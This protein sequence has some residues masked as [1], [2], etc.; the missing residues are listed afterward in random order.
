MRLRPW[1]VSMNFWE[2]VRWETTDER[3]GVRCFAEDFLKEGIRVS[4]IPGKC[5]MRHP[6][7]PSSIELGCNSC[8]GALPTTESSLF[9]L[10]R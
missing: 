8:L 3:M 2:K 5:N 10:M 1:L 9:A 4:W 6:T 7:R